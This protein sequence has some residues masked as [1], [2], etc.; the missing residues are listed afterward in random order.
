[1]A[2][3]QNQNVIGG[4]F[5][6]NYVTKMGNSMVCT[7]NTALLSWVMLHVRIILSHLRKS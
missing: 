7:G 3:F 6:L 2:A 1:M 4:I 5:K